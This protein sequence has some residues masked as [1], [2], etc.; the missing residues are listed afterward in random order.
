MMYVIH[1]IGQIG[2]DAQPEIAG[3]GLLGT[4]LGWFMYL[5]TK[6]PSA[7]H[8]SSQEATDRVIAEIKPLAHRMDGFSKALLIDVLSRDSTRPAVRDLAQAE[9]AK[10]DARQGRD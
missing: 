3:Y 6:V 10:I 9:L 5:G 4:V 2:M 7:I 8:K 1:F